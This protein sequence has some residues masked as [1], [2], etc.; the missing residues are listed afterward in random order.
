M[1]DQGKQSCWKKEEADFSKLLHKQYPASRSTKSGND[2]S[3]LIPAAGFLTVP[4]WLGRQEGGL[5]VCA[6]SRA[7]GLALPSF[8]ILFLLFYSFSPCLI[9]LNFRY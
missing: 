2:R 4:S 8:L 5:A 3:S 6:V 7:G 9:W 1:I